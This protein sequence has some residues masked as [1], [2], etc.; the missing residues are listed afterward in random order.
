MR[1]LC[2]ISFFYFTNSTYDQI[3]NGIKLPGEDCKYNS[4]NFYPLQG[5]KV[6]P[7]LQMM[8]Q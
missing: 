5:K 1:Q 2:R 4:A 6:L 3:V 7:I 8:G